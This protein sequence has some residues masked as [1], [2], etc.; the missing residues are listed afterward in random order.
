MLLPIPLRPGTEAFLSFQAYGTRYRLNLRI[1]GERPRT[2][3]V[4]PDLLFYPEGGGLLTARPLLPITALPSGNE[5]TAAYR[6]EP[7]QLMLLAIYPMTR[8]CL[9]PW[10]GLV[11]VELDDA[12]TQEDLRMAARK[13]LGIPT[14]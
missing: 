11:G 2:G 10:T 4:E 1:K 6:L 9:A 12:A 7:A 8:L 5:W 13:V 14:G 3:G